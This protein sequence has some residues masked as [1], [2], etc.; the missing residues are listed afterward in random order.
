MFSLEMT[1]L[2]GNSDLVEQFLSYMIQLY[3]QTKKV[4]IEHRA[5]PAQMLSRNEVQHCVCFHWK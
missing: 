5:L 2:L 1:L 4:L 3:N